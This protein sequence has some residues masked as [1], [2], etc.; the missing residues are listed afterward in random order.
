MLFRK[1]YSFQIN[2]NKD[3]LTQK[4]K[5][6]SKEYLVEK[7]SF[8]SDTFYSLEFNWDEFVVSRKAKMFERSAGVETDAYIRLI[9]IAENVTRIDVTIRFPEIA[10][11][12]LAFVQF[13]IIAGCLFGIESNW[14][15][16]ILIIIGSSGLLYF[17]IW[18]SVQG[19]N[20]F[21]KVIAGLFERVN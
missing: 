16:R 13:G 3:I 11:I 15:Y 5:D 18:I 17:F 10:W 8:G 20:P 19:S 2:Q 7:N 4:L 12:I 21:K 14:W 1:K 6:L 9:S